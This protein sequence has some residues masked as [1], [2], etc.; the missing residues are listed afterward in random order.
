MVLAGMKPEQVKTIIDENT[1]SGAEA[2]LYHSVWRRC[3]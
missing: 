1:F 2:K 3:Q